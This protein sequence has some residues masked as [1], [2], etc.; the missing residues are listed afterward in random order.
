MSSSSKVVFAKHFKFVLKN[1]YPKLSFGIVFKHCRQRKHT[2]FNLKWLRR[3]K[4]AGMSELWG[5]GG[6]EGG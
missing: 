2:P 3:Q 4:Q 5:S 1:F 6:Y